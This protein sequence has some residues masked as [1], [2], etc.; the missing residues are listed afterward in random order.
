MDTDHGTT[1]LPALL[2]GLVGVT[3]VLWGYRTLRFMSRMAC[4][5]LFVELGI[6]LVPQVAHS[7][8]AVAI[9][10]GAGLLGFLLG[11]AFYFVTVGLYGAAAGVLVP[12]ILNALLGGHPIGWAAGLVGGGVGALLAILFERPI[13]I[14][15]TSVLGGVLL[16]MAVH[17]ILVANGFH[18]PGRFTGAYG[19]LALVLTALGCWAQARSTKDLPPRKEKETAVPR[20][21]ESRA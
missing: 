8:S 16:T 21:R 2:S 11:N 5:L 1:L 10:V 6:L 17:A 12:A 7:A 4:F 14:A 20:G 13:G 3:Y 19:I 15:G 18:G 9:L